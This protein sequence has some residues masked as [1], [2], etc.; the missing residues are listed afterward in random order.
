MPACL[1][2]AGLGCTIETVEHMTK[3]FFWNMS[4]AGTPHDNAVME[5]IFGWFKEFLRSEYLSRFNEPIHQLLEKAV[6]EFNHFRPSYKL[7]YKSPVQFRIEQG[8][9]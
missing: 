5:S 8:F 1:G 6:F 2:V 3:A 7:H 9:G 4:R